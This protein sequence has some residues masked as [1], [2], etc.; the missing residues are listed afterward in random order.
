[1]T[2]F[3][4]FTTFLSCCNVQRQ[5]SRGSAPQVKIVKMFLEYRARDKNKEICQNDLHHLHYRESFPPVEE[6][7]L[8]GLLSKPSAF[9]WGTPF[10]SFG[11]VCRSLRRK[12]EASRCNHRRDLMTPHTGNTFGKPF[13]KVLSPTRNFLAN[14]PN[15]LRRRF[16]LFG[17]ACCRALGTSGWSVCDERR[18]CSIA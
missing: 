8:R 17:F 6:R 2:F 3:A 13:E 15:M 1:M 16:S 12:T 9:M 11:V 14:V 7:D 4:T 10:G 5:S 18:T